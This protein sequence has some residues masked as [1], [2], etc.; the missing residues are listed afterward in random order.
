MTRDFPDPADTLLER[1]NFVL[2]DGS[3]V[4]A[5]AEWLDKYSAIGPGPGLTDITDVDHE[6]AELLKVDINSSADSLRLGA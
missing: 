4:Q 2:A 5:N 3:M 6:A 1:V